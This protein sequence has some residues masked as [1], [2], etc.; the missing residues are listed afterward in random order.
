MHY[1]NFLIKKDIF[2]NLMWYIIQG[3]SKHYPLTIT[4]V[5][6][7]KRLNA[8]GIRPEDLEPVDVTTGKPKEVEPTFVDVVGQISLQSLDKNDRRRRDEDRNARNQDRRGNNEQRGGSNDRRNE[9]PQPQ[10]GAPREQRPNQPQRPPQNRGPQ[11]PRDNNGGTPRPPQ[12]P[13]EQ[14]PNQPQRPPQNRGPQQPREGGQRPLGPRPNQ[15]PPQ[16]RDRGPQT[17]REGG[18]KPEEKKD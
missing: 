12:A 5:K 7:I 10:Q 4:R 16:N 13:R 18:D 14:R 9:R 17:P 2:K 6:E 15:R 11:Q 3:G 1:N 8:Q